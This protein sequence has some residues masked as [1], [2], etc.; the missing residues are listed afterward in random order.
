MLAACWTLLFSVVLQ[1]FLMHWFFFFFFCFPWFH[2]VHFN[3]A[4]WL[5]FVQLQVQGWSANSLSCYT[6]SKKVDILLT[7][8]HP[9][10][11]TD[12]MQA[13]NFIVPSLN[14]FGRDKNHMVSYNIGRWFSRKKI[15]KNGICR[16][17]FDT[18]LPK[19]HKDHPG[20]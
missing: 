19:S 9:S 8:I 11:H 10:R 3:L 15:K 17:R 13:S 6:Q 20:L 16:V 7:Y 18:F 4:F 14:S 1:H 12:A 5:D 2:I